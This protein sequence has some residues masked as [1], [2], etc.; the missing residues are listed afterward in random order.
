MR[1]ATALGERVRYRT[2][3]NPWVGCIV[4]R[5]GVAIAEGATEPPGGRHGEVVALEAAGAAAQGST[6]VVTLEPCVHHG[7]TGPCTEALIAAG[8]A[9]VV[10]GVED[11]DPQ[12]AGAGRAALEAAGVRVTSGVESSMVETSLRA[13]LHHRRTG[14]PWVVWK[15][16][17]SIDGR[18]AARDGSSRWITDAESRRDGH[19]LRAAS[20][21]ILVGA[22]TALVDRPTL[23]VR[24]VADFDGPPPLRVVLDEQ[25]IVPA[26]G[27]LFDQKLAPTIVYTA[28]DSDRAA[29]EA[30]GAE[31]A[32]VPA[33]AAGV[34]PAAVLT[35]L[36]QRDVLQVLI[37][38][39]ARASGSF[40]ATD[41]VDE[42]VLYIAP[43][44]LGT[45]G[46]PAA[47]WDGPATLADAARWERTDVR[48]L[49]P[50]VRLTYGRRS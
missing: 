43:I 17:M 36:G 20:Q 45:R 34:D 44:L 30:A 12:V 24:D 46:L 11:P 9:E 13:Y 2:P 14:Q 3:P 10:I 27:P 21:A 31:V 39:G 16:A 7:R 19:L 18:I 48:A 41:L 47:V 28:A 26:G 33:T 50:D 49:G 29:W 6:V 15:A 32:T 40:L 5:D 22:G 8:V 4:L 38:G 1:R 25:G 42:A 35:E 37:E 23:T